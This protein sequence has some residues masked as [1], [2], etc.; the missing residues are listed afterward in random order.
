[1]DGIMLYFQLTL[2]TC[3]CIDFITRANYY[4]PFYNRS[5]AR[6]GQ[7]KSQMILDC[8]R[9]PQLTGEESEYREQHEQTYF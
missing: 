1:M 9:T 8:D 3:K 4:T 5:K 7:K 6:R 2:S